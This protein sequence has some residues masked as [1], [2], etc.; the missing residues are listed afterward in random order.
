[1]GWFVVLCMIFV[2]SYILDLFGFWLAFMCWC[3][4]VFLNGRAI[5]DFGLFSFVY[6]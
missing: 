6:L 2:F 3:F 1:M 5:S 4:Y